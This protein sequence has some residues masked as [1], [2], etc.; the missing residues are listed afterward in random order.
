MH[1]QPLFLG[2]SKYKNSDSAYPYLHIYKNHI[3]K[4]NKVENW[5]KILK[6]INFT[7]LL[8]VDRILSKNAFYF[9][10]I[11]F[12]YNPQNYICSNIIF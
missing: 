1:I 3:H 11:V 4:R 6:I 12:I 7:V 2:K 8:N 9:K 5:N 10:D